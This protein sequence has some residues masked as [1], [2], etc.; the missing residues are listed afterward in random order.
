MALMLKIKVIPNSGKQQLRIDKSGTIKC[1]LKKP[2]ENGKA[3][4]ELIKFISK[5]LSVPQKNV[6]II[7]GATSRKKTVHIDTDLTKEETLSQLG[8]E[9]QS[10]IT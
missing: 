7:Y 9:I 8:L 4:A 10:S 2:P 3:N 1:Y 5:K 6:K